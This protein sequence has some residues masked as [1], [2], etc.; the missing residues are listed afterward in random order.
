MVE[1][2]EEGNCEF[3]LIYS[4]THLKR[5]YICMHFFHIYS[6]MSKTSW[7]QLQRELAAY[8]IYNRLISMQIKN[9][10]ALSTSC[11]L[12]TSYLLL[13]P[14]QSRDNWKELSRAS[15]LLS[16]KGSGMLQNLGIPACSYISLTSKEY[17]R[18]LINQKKVH[19]KLCNIFV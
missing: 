7:V 6:V 10:K 1:L 8:L 16:H 15:T 19:L 11:L 3:A 9:S 4:S 5:V 17:Y 2:F 18:K 13:W 12:P 14:I